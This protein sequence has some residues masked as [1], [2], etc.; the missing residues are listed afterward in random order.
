M[1]VTFLNGLRRA[2]PSAVLDSTP[3]AATVLAGK[4]GTRVLRLQGRAFREALG[5]NP[6]VAGGVIRALAARIR[7]PQAPRKTAEKMASVD[8]GVVSQQR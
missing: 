1:K 3:R 4:E 5:A 6:S 7:G 8:S 2:Q